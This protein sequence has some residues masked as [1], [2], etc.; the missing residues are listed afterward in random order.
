M[1]VSMSM[2][3]E[4]EHMS[5]SAVPISTASSDSYYGDL[6]KYDKTPSR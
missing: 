6:F 5:N 1:S 3:I 4:N 2:G